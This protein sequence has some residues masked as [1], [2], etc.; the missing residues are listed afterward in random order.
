MENIRSIITANLNNVLTECKLNN[1]GEVYHGKVRDNYVFGNNRIIIASDRL[2]AFDVFIT[3]IPF[4]GQILSAISNYQFKAT[5]HIVANHMIEVLDPNVVLVKQCE[6]LPVEVVVRGY[7]AGSAWRSYQKNQ[8][9]HGIK[10]EPDLV[11]FAKFNQP[12]ITPSTKAPQGEHDMPLTIAEATNLMPPKLWSEIEEIALAL[13]A[14]G[15]RL[16]ERQGLILADTKYEFGLYDGKLTLVDEVHTLDC[17]RYW[18]KSS[19]QLGKVPQMLDK[20]PARRRLTELGFTGTEP[21]IKVTDEL[22]IDIGVTYWNAF[23]AVLGVQFNPDLQEPLG[24]IKQNVL[25]LINKD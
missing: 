16:A 20:E 8:I 19:Y 6:V 23:E 15:S 22:R 14:E 9:V 17:S 2:S 10:L 11:E 25:K 4:K 21:L 3:T 13:F 12:C 1:F 5:E 18:V 24:R 7:L